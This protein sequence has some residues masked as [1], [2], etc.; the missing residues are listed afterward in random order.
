MVIEAGHNL[1]VP[2]ELNIPADATHYDGAMVNKFFKVVGEQRWQWVLNDWQELT[3]HP[4]Y[5]WG[6]HNNLQPI[7]LLSYPDNVKIIRTIFGTGKMLG[8]EGDRVIVD[9]DCNPF[10]YRPAYLYKNDLL[11]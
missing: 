10:S 4:V 1:N 6:I 2:R 5:G 3:K 8:Y 11:P 7:E 9:L